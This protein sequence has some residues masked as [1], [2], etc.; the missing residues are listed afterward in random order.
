[1][2][3]ITKNTTPTGKIRYKADIRI[4]KAGKIIHRE[5]KTFDRKRLAEEWAKERE[6]TLQSKNELEKARFKHI[7][8][9]EVINRYINK[10]SPEEGFGRRNHSISRN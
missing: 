8:V 7:S 2:A 1:M 5:M 10:F 3:T 6:V 9:A 4:R